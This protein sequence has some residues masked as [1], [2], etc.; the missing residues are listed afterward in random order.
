MIRAAEQDKVPQCLKALAVGVDYYL[1]DI[2]REHT[3]P[4]RTFPRL[5]WPCKDPFCALA[6]ICDQKTSGQPDAP[7]IWLRTDRCKC[8]N[9]VGRS[10]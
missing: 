5:M 9:P 10:H 4:W 1:D 8:S 7:Y 2:P 6:W 3:Y